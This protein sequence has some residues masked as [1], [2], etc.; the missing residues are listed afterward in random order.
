LRAARG[1]RDHCCIEPPI[2]H[3]DVTTIIGL[4]GDIRYDVAAILRLLEDDDG[5]EEEADEADAE[6]QAEYDERTRKLRERIAE[7]EARER[8]YERGRATG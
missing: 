7:S 6:E 4:L 5:Q 1:A 2:E 8:E 3:R